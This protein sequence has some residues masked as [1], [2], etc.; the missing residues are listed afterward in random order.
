M[1]KGEK[2]ESR[3]SSRQLGAIILIVTLSFSALAS[4]QGPPPKGGK[5]KTHVVLE[6]ADELRYDR[7]YNPDVQRLLGN[8]VIKHEGAVMRCDSAHLNQKENTFEAFGQV[9]MQQGDTVSMFAR[10]LH[11]DGNIKYARLRHEVR[12]ENRSATLFTDSLDYDRVMNLG[13]YFEGGSI[14]DSLN[15]LTSSYGEYSP[16]TSDAIFRDNV[17]LENK[18]YTM[19]TEELHYNTDTKISHILGPTKMRSDSGYIVSTRGVYDSN[20]DVGILLDRS[21][22]YSSNGAKQLTGDSIFYDRRTGFGEAFGNMILTDTVNRSSLYGEYGYYDEKKDY[23]FATERSYMIDFSKPDTLWAAADT[24]EMITQRR[25]PEDRRIARGY[26]HVR[27]YRTDVQ[28]IAD[29]MQYDSRDSLLYLYDNPIMWNEGS[30]LSGDTIRFKFRNDSLDYVDVLTKALAVRRIDSIM[31]DQL[32]GRRIRAYMQ[33]SL[34]R[35]IQVHGNAEVIQYEQHKRSKRWYLMNRIE[36]PSIIADFEEGQLK[37]VLL[38]GVASGKGY[39]IKM[40][41][42]DLQRLASFRWEETIRPKSEKDLFR[43]QPDSVL[44]VHRSLSDLRRFSGALAALRAYRALA[45]EERK[46]SL[47]VAALQTDSIPPTS[48][49]NKEVANPT[50]M[51]SPYIARPTTDSKEEDF[52]DLFFTPLIFN[53]EQLWD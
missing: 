11:Y 10:Y 30:Q 35:Q 20:T 51:L 1:R 17:H 18:D 37:K 15:T 8:V 19:D 21:I 23:A 16:A 48:S 22:V 49:D 36:S 52:F 26:R 9:S 12:L 42:P 29:S 7:L 53:R 5:G 14:V 40:L 2:H 43:R 3:L 27:V 47:T 28:A 45:E 34:V 39:P 13:Y 24:L 33:D 50:N 41:T 25:V 44:Q 38:Q 46:D 31:Y 6:H 4:L 32:A